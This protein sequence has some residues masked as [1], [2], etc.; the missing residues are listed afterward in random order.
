[1]RSKVAELYENG[2]ADFEMKT[3][4]VTAVS[5]YQDQAGFEIRVGPHISR[6][7]LEIEAEEFQQKDNFLHHD[8]GARVAFMA[9]QMT[10][11]G[12]KRKQ[13]GSQGTA[14]SGGISDLPGLIPE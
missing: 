10:T 3:D 2:L 4:V 9:S 14:A 5:A 7:Y 6:A 11:S 13:K 8:Q 1:M 12:A